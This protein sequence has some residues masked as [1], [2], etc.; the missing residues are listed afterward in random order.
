MVSLLDDPVDIR[1]KAV[2]HEQNGSFNHSSICGH[3]PDKTEAVSLHGLFRYRKI[4]DVA[5]RIL[6]VDPDAKFGQV[7]PMIK[8][9]H[10]EPHTVH[11]LVSFYAQNNASFRNG[12]DTQMLV[13]DERKL[14]IASCL[15]C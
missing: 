7:R 8:A 3:G 5:V 6:V 9:I 13:N 14:V 11:I 10:P 12:D 2:H 1:H 4:I 15:I